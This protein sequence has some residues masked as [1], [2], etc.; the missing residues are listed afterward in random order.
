MAAKLRGLSQ[1]REV[2]PGAKVKSLNPSGP[3]TPDSGG[4]TGIS[5]ATMDPFSSQREMALGVG[6]HWEELHGQTGHPWGRG[7]EWQ[8][9]EPSVHIRERVPSMHLVQNLFQAVLMMTIDEG[10]LGS[11]APVSRVGPP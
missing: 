10:C 1:G 11:G 3:S 2:L 7:G 5:V 6:R 4:T 8:V 9:N